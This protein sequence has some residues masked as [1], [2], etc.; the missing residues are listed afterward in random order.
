MIGMGHKT[1]EDWVREF[2][3]L[4]KDN[5]RVGEGF[6]REGLDFRCSL[7]AEEFEELMDEFTKAWSEIDSKG[8]VTKDTKENLM[9]EL[10]DLLFVLSGMAV[11]FK[12]L[13]QVQP[14]FVRVSMSNLSKADP[15][16][17]EIEKNSKGKIVK[18]KHYKA[19]DLEDLVDGKR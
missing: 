2:H 3:N 1:R 19:P 7:I 16:T 5:P 17:R 4:D 8:F 15:F 18:S 12:D 13:A 11:Q 10:C 14:A 9:K 6:T